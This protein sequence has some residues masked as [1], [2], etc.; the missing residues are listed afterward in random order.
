MQIDFSAAVDRVNHQ[1]IFYVLCSVCIG[2]YVLSIL[3]KFLS[4]RSQHVNV[5]GR[6]SKLVNIVSRVPQGRVFG[7][8][9]FLL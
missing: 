4:N 5:D 1:H 7:A 9:L 2:G 8:L 3:A 6:L